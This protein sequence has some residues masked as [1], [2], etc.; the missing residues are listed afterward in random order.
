MP[1][2]HFTSMDIQYGLLNNLCRVLKHVIGKKINRAFS[3]DDFRA[4]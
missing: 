3:T 2:N 4:N 1:Y